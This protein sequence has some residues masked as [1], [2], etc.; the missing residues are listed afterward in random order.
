MKGLERFIELV[1]IANVAL[2]M[3]N[4]PFQAKCFEIAGVRGKV[5]GESRGTGS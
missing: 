1:E 2:M 5:G 4:K 3:F